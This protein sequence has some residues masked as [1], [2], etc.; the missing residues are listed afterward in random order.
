MT[1]NHRGTNLTQCQVAK[2]ADRPAE[3]GGR[4]EGVHTLVKLIAR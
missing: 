3:E 4:D 1:N 2:R